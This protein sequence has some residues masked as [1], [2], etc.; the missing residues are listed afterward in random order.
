MDI[1]GRAAI[2]PGMEGTSDP[3]AAQAVFYDGGC[4]ICR[5]EIAA[6]RHMR[7][8]DAI[9]WRD[10]TDAGTDLSGLDRDAAMARFHARRA[11]GAIVS[12][13]AAFLAVWRRSDRLRPL[14]IVLDRQPFRGVL[15]LGYRGFLKI[16]PLWRR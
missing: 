1:A 10:V 2:W 13:A 9:E 6:Y 8:M 3:A 14:A 15:E 16:R 7:G 12:G 5:R 11:D 4:P